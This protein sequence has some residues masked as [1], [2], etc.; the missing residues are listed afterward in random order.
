M[1]IHNFTPKDRKNIAARVK[2]G[3]KQKDIAAEYGISTGY[4]SKIVKKEKERELSDVSVPRQIDLSQFTAD[5]LR[6]RYRM[7]HIELLKHNDELQQ[8][9][10][11]ADG[12]QRSIEAESAKA[13]GVRDEN[14]ILAQRK[15]LTWCQD[16]T[17]IAYEIARLYQEASAI[18]QTFAKRNVPVPVGVSIR[19]GLM[20]GSKVE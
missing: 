6:N 16:T 11:E 9:L 10:R 2:S 4:L 13:D 20:R 12:L 18:A 5:Q 8:R 1:N 19:N 14:W 7:I 3:E 17:Q 15:R